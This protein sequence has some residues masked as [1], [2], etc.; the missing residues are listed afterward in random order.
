[1]P[2]K[3]QDSGTG[4]P[5]HDAG[6]AALANGM[7]PDADDATYA[8][9]WR[10]F[11]H[12][13]LPQIKRFVESRLGDVDDAVLDEV[14]LETEKRIQRGIQ[15]FKDRGPGKL[16]SWCL[17]V[18][19]RTLQD[20]WRGHAPFVQDGPGDA[21]ELVSFDEIAEKYS[22]ARVVGNLDDCQAIA[23]READEY[24]DDPRPLTEREQ[25]IREAFD[26][27]PDVDQVLIWGRIDGDSDAY[28]ASINGKPVDQVRKIRHKAI[29]K[30][31][32][33]FERLMASRRQ[34]S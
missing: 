11:E 5:W 19:Q 1:M 12:R 17:K 6:D 24:D 4:G 29:S 9:A 28:L 13:H 7:R 23:G 3:G 2:N 30:L 15:T 21:G 32:K 22:L 16:R 18:T 25:V 14:L 31:A 33:A 26:T 20:Y 8:L 27:L 34:V 10:E